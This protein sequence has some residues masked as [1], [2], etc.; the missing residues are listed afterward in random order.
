[1]INQFC[2]K[3]TLSQATGLSSSTLKHYRLSGVW[4]E[5]IHWQ[6]LNSRCILYNLPLILDWVASRNCPGIHQ[7]AIENYLYAL[8]SNQ[9]KRKRGN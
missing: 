9:R 3:R 4:T 7:R 5:G 6:R 8:P 2:N 1:M